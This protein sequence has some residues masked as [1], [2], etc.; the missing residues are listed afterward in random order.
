MIRHV[1]VIGGGFGGLGLAL[2]LSRRGC[3]VT[4]V[5]RDP[6]P[7][8]MD[9]DYA[10]E[11]WL[12]PGVP[13]VRQ[14]HAFVARTH[15]ILAD[16]A[17]DVLDA[18]FSI[19]VETVNPLDW[20]PADDAEAQDGSLAMLAMRRTTYELV[21]R[22]IAASEPRIRILS[23]AVADGLLFADGTSPVTV[24][25][26]RLR[27]GLEVDADLVVDAGGRLTP[28]P[29]WLSERGAALHE[30]IEP[31]GIVYY[32]R[33][34]RRTKSF[35]VRLRP[36]SG[37]L[38]YMAYAVGIGDLGTYPVVLQ[39]PS[40]DKAFRM[41]RHDEVWEA[42]VRSIP[43]LAPW[44]DPANAVA[45]DA[46]QPMG[47]LRNV[48]RSFVA[49]GRPIVLGIVPVGDALCTTTPD[50]AWGAS[51]ALTHAVA[52]AGLVVEHRDDVESLAL[53]Y[54]DAVVPEATTYFEYAARR[55]RVRVLRRKGEPIPNDDQ[56]EADHHTLLTNG[57]TPA[58]RSDAHV[59]RAMARR[60]ALVDPPEAIW[61]D[62]RSIT[63]ALDVAALR[64]ATGSAQP[65]G[66]ER[67]EMARIMTSARASR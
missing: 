16:L 7:R 47:G 52:L 57:L 37:D 38:G 1:A 19:G 36:V 62:E 27:G 23:P 46:V 24:C 58:T 32:N 10:F 30:R 9:P 67:N 31:C 49:D 44:I 21:L 53:A 43:E 48:L 25:G 64:L 28:V 12:R 45:L 18:L 42:A 13:Q 40:W 41:L 56:E 29:G 6:A 33:Y 26:V 34:L 66:P 14:P 39:P 20:I 3:Q 11:N 22:R 54:A 8:S 63:T 59:A 15:E 2:A 4:V 60:N 51:F 17:P 35:D 50:F 5:E 55:D 65:D 61:S